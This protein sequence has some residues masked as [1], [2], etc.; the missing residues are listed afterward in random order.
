[1]STYSP[2]RHFPICP[3]RAT[4]LTHL[5]FAM[6][7]WPDI[8]LCYFTAQ[9]TAILP[10]HGM[11]CRQSDS[12]EPP[13]RRKQRRKQHA[14]PLDDKIQRRAWNGSCRLEENRSRMS[15]PEEQYGNVL[16]P[17]AS[18]YDPKLH[19]NNSGKNFVQIIGRWGRVRKT[20]RESITAR[21]SKC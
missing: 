8:I 12:R 10:D 5:H 6:R 17:R 20:I 14:I 21:K 19:A 9:K 13:N 1:M 11:L 2:S 16:L 15:K 3:Q 4:F 18:K 7:H